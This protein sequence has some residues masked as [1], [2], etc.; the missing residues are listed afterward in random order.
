M[1]S[2][3]YFIFILL[4]ILL[5]MNNLNSSLITN[6]IPSL[7]NYE[8][9]NKYINNK[10]EITLM[11]SSIYLY[12]VIKILK[13]NTNLLY[14]QLIDIICV[15]FP[16][17]LNRFEINYTLLSLKYNNRI[18]IKTYTDEITSI[19]SITSLYSCANWSEREVWDMYGILFIGNLDLRRILTDYGFEGHPLR[20]DFPL[21]GYHEVIYD[22]SLKNI[23]YQ[24][25]SLTQQF[26]F[27]DY[28]SAW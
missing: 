16:E 21:S 17:R 1:I 20:K 4:K 11:I 7:I 18:N 12:K 25:I 28:K 22:D 9:T 27:F 23:T 13:L 3:I 24:N 6:I 10:K 5:L 8:K 2:I 26:R 14:K 19:N 15:D